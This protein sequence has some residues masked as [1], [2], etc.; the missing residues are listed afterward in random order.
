MGFGFSVRESGKKVSL[1]F[2]QEV[3]PKKRFAS[4]LLEDK[5]IMDIKNA[6]NLLDSSGDLVVYE[7]YNL[8]KSD[9]FAKRMLR[10]SRL[11]ADITRLNHGLFSLGKTGELFCT[12]GHAHEGFSGE[13]YHVIKNDCFILLSD[14]KNFKTFL[15]PLKEKS[16][17]FIHPTFMHRLVCGKRDSIVLG[18]VP[19]EAGHD[20]NIV[21]NMGFPF[22]VF[23]DDKIKKILL[24]KNPK[25]SNAK[26][27]YVEKFRSKFDA[28]KLVKGREKFLAEV[29]R[30]PGKHKDIYFPASTK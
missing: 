27:T 19:E 17:I 22:H 3:F 20:Y 23:S 24:K 4:E 29:L 13:V 30:S 10:D 15:V 16:S 12:Y 6:K 7:V 1:K 21:K 14:K 28:M 2:D 9:R 5:V 8:W 25:Y 18:F 11:M 26:F